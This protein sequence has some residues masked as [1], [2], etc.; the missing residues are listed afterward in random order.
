[1]VYNEKNLNAGFV[2][3]DCEGVNEDN[4]TKKIGVPLCGKNF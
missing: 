1:M 3:G 4:L 2:D